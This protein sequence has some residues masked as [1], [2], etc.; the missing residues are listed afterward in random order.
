MFLVLHIPSGQ[1]LWNPCLNTYWQFSVKRVADQLVDPACPVNLLT[2]WTIKSANKQV[3]WD[4]ILLD[5]FEI[6]EVE[7]EMQTFDRPASETQ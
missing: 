1:F 2:D 5:E 7:N 6:V 4:N 3:D